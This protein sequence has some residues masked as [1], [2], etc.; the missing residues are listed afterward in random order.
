MADKS[1][2]PAKRRKLVLFIGMRDDNV[3]WERLLLFFFV[4]TAS[5]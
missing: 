4:F 2:K 5:S 3:I 1:Q